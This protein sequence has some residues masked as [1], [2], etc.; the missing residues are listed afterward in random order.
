[1]MNI[2]YYF[3]LYHIVEYTYKNRS[4]FQGTLFILL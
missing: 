1:M 3:E 4:L 2:D